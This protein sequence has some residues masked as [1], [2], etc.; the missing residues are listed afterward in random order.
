M[1]V[2]FGLVGSISGELLTYHGKT[3]VHPNRYELEWLFPGMR[4][5]KLNTSFQRPTMPVKDHP[6]LAAVRW[7]LNKEDFRR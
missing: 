4:V 3:L 2:Q 1:S 7:P 6:D 5:V